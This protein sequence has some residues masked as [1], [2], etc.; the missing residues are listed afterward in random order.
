MVRLAR[1][2]RGLKLVCADAS[3]VPADTGSY[4]TVVVATGVLRGGPEDDAVLRE[5]RRLLKPSGI[6]IVGVYA[7]RRDEVMALE[8]LGLMQDNTLSQSRLIEL[9]EAQN[10]AVDLVYGWTG[11]TEISMEGAHLLTLLIDRVERFAACLRAAGEEPTAILRQ[12]HRWSMQGWDGPMLE[13]CLLG[14]HVSILH[15]SL[16]ADTLMAVSRVEAIP[17]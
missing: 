17:G 7:P 5:A 6:L 3:N 8:E 2:R 1:E 9:W 13:E 11:K 10:K 15:A 16:Q 4:G 12:S 14:H